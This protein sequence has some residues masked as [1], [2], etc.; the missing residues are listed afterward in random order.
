MVYQTQRLRRNQLVTTNLRT[1]FAAKAKLTTRKS[2]PIPSLFAFSFKMASYLTN[3]YNNFQ[4]ANSKEYISPDKG[5]KQDFRPETRFD[6]LPGNSDL[7]SA[8]IEKCATQFGY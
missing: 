6:I 8:E 3:P 1:L 2:N 5:A 4:A 7:F